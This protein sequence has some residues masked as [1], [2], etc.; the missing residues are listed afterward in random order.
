M[1]IA[2]Q[3]SRNSQL[4]HHNLIGQD[5]IWDAQ[6][7]LCILTCSRDQDVRP[8]FMSHF[9][10]FMIALLMSGSESLEELF[11]NSTDA[12][13]CTTYD[14]FRKELCLL[15]FLTSS[16]GSVASGVLQSVPLV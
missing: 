5:G 11:V 10:A 7:I 4:H 8:F 1:S 15:V 6:E 9:I 3:N 2:I 14:S 12:S 13:F 16:I